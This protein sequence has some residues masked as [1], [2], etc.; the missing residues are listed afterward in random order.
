MKLGVK[1]LMLVYVSP[2]SDLAK[3]VNFGTVLEIGCET[4]SKMP[5][6]RLSILI[7]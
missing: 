4:G 7:D 3:G 1:F 2:Y 5:N 6:V